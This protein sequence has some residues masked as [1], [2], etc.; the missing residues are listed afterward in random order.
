MGYFQPI[1]NETGH[2][3]SFFKWPKTDEAVTHKCTLR[4]V[5]F[6]MHK[7]GLP[8]TALVFTDTGEF[9]LSCSIF[10][11]MCGLNGFKSFVDRV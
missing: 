8:F 9:D 5:H 11:V 7:S 10:T 2:G 3:R 1:E 4:C 6:C